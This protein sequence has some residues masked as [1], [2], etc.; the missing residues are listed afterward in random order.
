MAIN[1]SG[2]K[3]TAVG[4]GTLGNNTTASNSTAIGFNALLANNANDNTA[5]GFEAMLVSDSG[6]ATENTAIGSRSMKSNRS[7]DGNTAAGR[8]S[9]LNNVSGGDNVAIGKLAMAVNNSGSQNVAVGNEALRLNSTGNQNVAV[10]RES[11]YNNNSNYTTIV[12]HQAGYTANNTAATF[13]TLFGYQAGY[14]NV[15]GSANTFIGPYSGYYITGNNNTILG[16]YDGNM[17]GL[18]I[19]TS[20]NNVVL[21]DG[22]GN[23]RLRIDSSGNAGIGTSSPSS[24]KFS[25]T[26]SG[27]LE[28]KGSKPSFNVQESDV[29]NAHFNMSMSGGIAYL[30][31]TGTGNLILATGTSTWAERMRIDAT[32][33]VGIGTGGTLNDKLVVVAGGTGILVARHWSGTATSGQGLGEIGFK[34]YADGNSTLASDAKITGRLEFYVKHPSTGPG[35]APTRRMQLSSY[36]E[37]LLE[38]GANNWASFYMN[39][40]AGIRYHVKRFYTGSSGVTENVMRVKR[41][42]WGSG[43]YKISVKQQYYSTVSEQDFYINGHGRNDGSYS[44]SYSLTYKDIHN[45][46]SG[47]INLTSPVASSPGNSAANYVDAQ[48]S[49]PAYTHWI[50]VIEAGGMAGYSQSVSSMSGNDMYALH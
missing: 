44:P 33:N 30:G 24:P 29:T 48:I 35:S 27:I 6:G 41:H 20:S 47:R 3:N 11:A 36:G 4:V 17:D 18:D 26:A 45:G 43:F 46:S 16:R 32:G 1:S 2:A 19:R 42:Y 39:E 40:Q 34:G 50:V 37:L 38:D 22:A 7:G 10:G 13:N 15:S 21:A 5:V 49:I 25:S 8:E 9:L 14:S 23:I 31:A 28:L 12:G